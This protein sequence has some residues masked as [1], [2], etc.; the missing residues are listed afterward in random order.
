MLISDE[1]VRQ[2][3]ALI[4]DGESGHALHEYRKATGAHFSDAVSYVD[5]LAIELGVSPMNFVY[6][7]SL[8]IAKNSKDIE[9]FVKSKTVFLIERP[10]ELY[11]C[12]PLR[13]TKCFECY[14]KRESGLL[15]AINLDP[16]AVL[17][18][19]IAYL[20]GRDD[21]SLEGW[22]VLEDG[23]LD[24]S[25]FPGSVISDFPERRWGPQIGEVEKLE[26]QSEASGPGGWIYVLANSTMKGILKIGRT[27]RTPSERADEL[28]AATG[29]P[30][31]FVIVWQEET[32]DSVSAE[33]EV[34]RL[35]EGYRVNLGREFFQ[36][37]T[38]T[39]IDIVSRACWRFAKTIV[40]SQ[41]SNEVEKEI[42]EFRDALK[43]LEVT[44]EIEPIT[45]RVN[46][47]VDLERSRQIFEKIKAAGLV[48][49]SGESFSG[50]MVRNKIEEVE[51]MIEFAKKY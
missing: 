16:D 6:D 25:V 36:I 8:G 44:G 49:G 34:H 13:N 50:D 33:Q 19:S 2:L 30:T 20:E 35:L 26:G 23:D 29:V 3:K 5:R 7:E 21:D 12:K 22:T 47:K 31:P 1:L 45:I 4:C 39:A 37:D 43:I 27:D 28:S 40:D 48:S 14:V 42:L 32:G 10:K 24:P 38:K 17:E 41:N 51:A 11:L 46:L 18:T 15:V 9:R